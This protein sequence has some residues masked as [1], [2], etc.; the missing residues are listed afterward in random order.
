MNFHGSFIGALIIGHGSAALGTFGRI[1]CFILSL[2]F[3]IASFR[4]GT[5]LR[6]AFSY[7]NGPGV[8][9]VSAGRLILFLIAVVLFLLSVGVL[10]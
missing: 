4:R 3:G 9:I 10:K 1:I 5:Q 7:G 6:A 8:P 2:L